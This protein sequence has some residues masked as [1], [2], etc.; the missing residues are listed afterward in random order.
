MNMKCERCGKALNEW[1]TYYIGC[2]VVC[3]SCIKKG[4]CG[5][6]HV[7]GGG[8]TIKDLESLPTALLEKQIEDKLFEIDKEA[9][10]FA[11]KYIG[12]KEDDDE[13]GIARAIF[14]SSGRTNAIIK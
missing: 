5:F 8:F 2:T 6:P 10:Q 7:Q 3:K 9:E 12:E 4:E 11:N 1:N 14:E 13:I